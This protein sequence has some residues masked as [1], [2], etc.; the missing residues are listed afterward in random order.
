MA[1]LWTLMLL[2]L[3]SSQGKAKLFMSNHFKQLAPSFLSSLDLD[4]E[5]KKGS[6]ESLEDETEEIIQSVQNEK[7]KPI[8]GSWYWN[9]LNMTFVWSIQRPIGGSDRYTLAFK[10]EGV[11]FDKAEGIEN[12]GELD[13][14]NELK[15]LE[16]LVLGSEAEEVLGSPTGTN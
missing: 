10:H 9:P 14:E 5:G 6:E 16:T 11:E 12:P 7:M 15:N 4:V 2:L 3:G 1:L 8:Q 13:D